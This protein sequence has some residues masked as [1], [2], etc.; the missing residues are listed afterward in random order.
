MNCL[1]FATSLPSSSGLG[2]DFIIHT[3]LATPGPCKE[4]YFDSQIRLTLLA[5][6]LL[7]KLTYRESYR[8]Q[9]WLK[10]K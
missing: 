1:T 7:L 6:F 5:N 4:Q 9:L 8:R 2:D 3:V 10:R